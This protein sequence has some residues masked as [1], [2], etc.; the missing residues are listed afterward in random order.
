VLGRARGFLGRC[1]R[2]DGVR[3]VVL[4]AAG[5]LASWIAMG[6]P[7]SPG[8][9]A[10]F[11][12]STEVTLDGKPLRLDADEARTLDG[13]RTIARSYVAGKITVT[14]GSARTERTREELGAH[15]DPSRLAAL[16]AEARDPKSAMRRAHAQ[17][18]RGTKLALPLPVAADATRALLALLQVKDE[19]DRPPV[20]ARLDPARGVMIPEQAG[21]R[22]DVYATLARLDDAFTRGA[23]SVEAVVDTV[24]PTRPAERL[25]GA[26]T[27][28][29][30]GYFETKY[31]RDQKHEARTFNLR[32]A[33]SKLDGY[34]LL[35]GETF[36]FNEVVGARDEA[37]GYK[38]APVI[39]SGELVD[40]IGGGTCQIAGTI[41]GAAYFA[42]LDIVE[43]HP[44]TRPSF[45]IK[46][47]MDA[48]VAFPTISLKLRNPYPFP[49]VL[50]ETVTG[51][52]VRAEILGP[53]RLRDVTFV[54]KIDEVVPFQEKEAD[55]PT[56]PA[57]KRAL[58]QRGIPG[59]KITRYRIVRDGSFAVRE[60][61]ED[62]YP[63]TT[64]IW[65]VGTGAPDPSFLPHDDE[66]PEY[67]ADEY[68]MITQGP[69]VREPHARIA[70]RG[71][72]TL[73]SRVAGRFGTHGWTKREGFAKP[74]KE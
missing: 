9:G 55:A 49:V 37:S 30:L 68:L 22:I 19:L 10:V 11:D 21:Q 48:A 73:E 50:H 38:V 64:Q 26:S 44:H 32:L 66:H 60:K 6:S 15:I 51:G 33:A 5:S 45:Y 43:R 31:A 57:G 12:Q 58:A 70:Q 63:A 25:V 62:K 59:F 16:I 47:G 74:P 3:A 20:D 53:R 27:K 14:L 36:D 46:M 29:V 42:G 65:K 28:D 40:G 72:V 39:A 61:S 18:A 34:V 13:A 35:P 41:H 2:K 56:I 23:P 1:D 67:V 24:P 4:L 7:R 8:A 17:V 69:D 54:R 71:G 52:V